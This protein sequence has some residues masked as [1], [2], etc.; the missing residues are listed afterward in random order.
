MANFLIIRDLCEK[1]N[2][3]IRNLAKQIGKDDSSIQA[4]MRAGSTSTKT[5]ED[6]ARVLGVPVGVFFDGIPLDTPRTDGFPTRDAEIEYLKT[7]I[8]EKERT[9]QILLDKVGK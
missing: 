9:I 8:A 7:I 1:R 5:I 2:I 6:I 4:L 3:S